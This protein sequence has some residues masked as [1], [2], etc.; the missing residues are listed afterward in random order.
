MVLTVLMRNFFLACLQFRLRNQSKRRECPLGDD[1]GNTIP[2][3]VNF[4]SRHGYLNRGNMQPRFQ[5][6]SHG[7]LKGTAESPDFG[8][9]S[10]AL[11]FGLVRKPVGKVH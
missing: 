4:S 5:S 1:F 8:D 6:G 3:Y 9:L 2:S 11:L 10:A 7:E